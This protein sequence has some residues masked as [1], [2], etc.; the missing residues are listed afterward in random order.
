MSSQFL[1]NAA[2][3]HELSSRIPKAK[4]VRAAVAYLGKGGAT[5][6]PLRK[7]D[8]LVVNMSLGRV[9][10]GATDPKEVRKLLKRGVSVFSRGSLHAKFLVI[11]NVVIAGSSNVSNHAKNDLDEAA[12]LTNDTATVQ[13][14]RSTFEKLC[15]ELVR[16]DYLAKCI[17]EYRPPKFTGKSSSGKKTKGKKVVQSKLWFLAG[18]RYSSIPESEKQDA[19]AVVKKAKKLLDFEKSEVDYCHYPAKEKF[20]SSLREDDWLIQCIREGKGYEVWAPSRFMGIESYP[21]GGGKRRYL[22]LLETPLEAEATRWTQLRSRS[23]IP[24]PAKPRRIPVPD[25][26]DADAI[27][28]L[29]DVRGRFK[30]KK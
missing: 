27:L 19:D 24:L 2:L 29:W 26:A 6:L 5:L 10:A 1:F 17:K 9:R 23:P 30:K 7:G 13:R 12:V 22:L 11:D 14:A 3:W 21:R 4:K 16:K 28:R 25:D 20:F 15:T 18:L 8:V